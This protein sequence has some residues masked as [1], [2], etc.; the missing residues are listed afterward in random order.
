MKALPASLVLA[1]FGCASATRPNHSNL[2]A[3]GTYLITAEQIEK[4]GAHT[5]WQV[6]KQQA[7]M[8]MLREDRNGRPQ[9][10]G[11]RGRSSFLLDEAP[12]I[13]LDGVRVPDFHALESIDAQSI[14]SIM[15]YDGV[16]GTTYYG[17]GAVSGVIVI[18]SKGGQSPS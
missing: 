3:P 4:T 18:T 7:P 15:I 9:S 12:M 2:G 14:F 5:A 1:L 17:T 6:L 13:M 11:R 16:E 8:L 10:M